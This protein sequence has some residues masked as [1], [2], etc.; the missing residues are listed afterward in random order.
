M[1]IVRFFFTDV[2]K[3]RYSP[4]TAAAIIF[5]SLASA[6]STRGF[7]SYKSTDLLSLT[8]PIAGTI[9]ALPLPAAQ[10]AQSVIENFLS[11]AR[12]LIKARKSIPE[13]IIYLTDSAVERRRNLEAMKCVV[14]YGAVSFLTGMIGAFGFL[15]DTTIGHMILIADFVAC[16]ATTFL[17]SSI[18]WFFPVVLSSFDFRKGD[19]LIELLESASQVPEPPA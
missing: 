1:N 19:K 8:L 6:Q 15:K 17:V 4:T 9:V 2:G 11:S 18:L 13:I 10:L 3:V 14:I 5:A 12:D 7:L 16:A